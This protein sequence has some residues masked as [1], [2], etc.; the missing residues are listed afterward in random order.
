MEEL[1]QQEE[2]SQEICKDYLT[3]KNTFIGGIK[4]DTEEYHQW[5]YFEQY[6]KTKMVEIITDQGKGKKR[7]FA[8]ITLMTMILWIGLSF[9]NTI[10]WMPQLWNEESSVVAGDG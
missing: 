3:V 6:G 10:L 2:L 5:D 7:G 9:R 4:E 8:F 1:W